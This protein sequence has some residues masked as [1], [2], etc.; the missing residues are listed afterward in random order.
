MCILMEKFIICKKDNINRNWS[1]EYSS[2]LIWSLFAFHIHKVRFEN[3]RVLKFKLKTLWLNMWQI[4][5]ICILVDPWNN[6]N[7]INWNA[8]WT[9]VPRNKYKRVVNQNNNINQMRCTHFIYWWIITFIIDYLLCPYHDRH[10]KSLNK[11]G[12]GNDL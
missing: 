1:I 5:K 4:T 11:K 10:W 7:Q 9:D 2:N 6:I 8:A 12:L 3:S